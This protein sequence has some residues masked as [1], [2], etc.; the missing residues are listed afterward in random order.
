MNEIIGYDESGSG[1]KFPRFSGPC[2]RCGSTNYGLSTSGP[3]Y[4]A[5]CAIGTPVEEIRLRRDL[6]AAHDKCI[7]LAFAL[8]LALGA[9]VFINDHCKQRA[10]RA[11]AE[12][13]AGIPQA[14]WPT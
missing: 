2:K 10:E 4:C 8:Q 3:D 5:Q 6:M 14:C 1:E 11:L 7:D 12:F 9:T 13:K